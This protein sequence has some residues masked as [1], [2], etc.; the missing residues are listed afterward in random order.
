M[1]YT[2]SLVVP[3]RCLPTGSVSVLFGMRQKVVSTYPSLFGR[4]PLWVL[5]GGLGPGVC[6][7][8]RMRTPLSNTHSDFRARRQSFQ[9]LEGQASLSRSS[10]SV[11]S[12]YVRCPCFMYKSG[13]IS[14]S[15]HV[16]WPIRPS[17]R[18][19]VLLLATQALT[20]S[21]SCRSARGSAGERL[22]AR[23]VLMRGP[24]A[25]VPAGAA[26]RSLHRSPL[27]AHP[28]TRTN[29]R[30]PTLAPRS[31]LTG[32]TR[33]AA[34]IDYL[35]EQFSPIFR[36]DCLQTSHSSLNCASR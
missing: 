7:T 2:V 25:L 36:A 11:S 22:T 21:A 35:T 30:R 13:I 18:P 17:A 28:T 16:N 15:S 4:M 32:C 23:A 10:P 12:L 14:P 3:Q 27:S 24:L 26:E 33:Q 9:W 31:I 1:A 19:T 34:T 5:G 6:W 29:W 8:C 20:D